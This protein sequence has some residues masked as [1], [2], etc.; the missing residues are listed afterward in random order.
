MSEPFEEATALPRDAIADRLEL[1]RTPE[2]RLRQ[3]MSGRPIL[4]IKADAMTEYRI[5]THTM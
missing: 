5:A 1:D 4:I 2:V 3:A